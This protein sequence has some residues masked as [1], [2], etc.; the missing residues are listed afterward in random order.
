MNYLR[1]P[2]RRGLEIYFTWCMGKISYLPI[3]I[4]C[5]FPVWPAIQARAH[6]RTSLQPDVWARVK[7]IRRV[8]WASERRERE[9]HGRPRTKTVMKQMKRNATQQ[10]SNKV[11]VFRWCW[12]EFKEKLGKKISSIWF[13]RPDHQIQYIMWSFQLDG[14]IFPTSINLLFSRSVRPRWGLN[15]FFVAVVWLTL[16]PLCI[17]STWCI[18]IEHFCT[19]SRSW[20]PAVPST[21]TTTATTKKESM[22]T[23]YCVWELELVMLLPPVDLAS[24]GHRTNREMAIRRYSGCCWRFFFSACHV[25]LGGSSILPGILFGVELLSETA[26]LP[27]IS[28]WFRCFWLTFW[29][30]DLIKECGG[31][32]CSGFNAWQQ[33]SGPW[34][35][36]R[37][38]CTWWCGTWT[39][40]IKATVCLMIFR[41][42]FW[43]VLADQFRGSNGV[44]FSVD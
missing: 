9:Q 15:F 4:H 37:I 20:K 12:F 18:L 27:S 16:A 8:W 35:S 5:R 25:L 41:V 29:S 1:D 26:I 31:P 44:F 22:K 23:C 30:N 2:L 33:I 11:E 3:N 14:E 24:S 38:N 32:H 6:R 21:T 17:V 43:F 34:R 13:A 39:W 28:E 36:K 19:K 40:S 42:N 10:K 7:E